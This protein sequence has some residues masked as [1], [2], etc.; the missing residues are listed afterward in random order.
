M[1]QHNNRW[2]SNLLHM[3]G[4][5]CKFWMFRV[6]LFCYFTLFVHSNDEKP[7]NI[8]YSM[9]TYIGTTHTHIPKHT[10]N[11]IEKFENCYQITIDFYPF[12]AKSKSSI[13]QHSPYVCLCSNNF[14]RSIQSIAS[15]V[16]YFRCK[17]HC[18]RYSVKSFLFQEK[19]VVRVCYRC[20][21]CVL[22][23]LVYGEYTHSLMWVRA[24][25][26]PMTIQKRT[27][28]FNANSNETYATH[29]HIHNLHNSARNTCAKWANEHTTQSAY[30]LQFSLY[31]HMS[32]CMCILEMIFLSRFA[33][34]KWQ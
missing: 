13:G 16:W 11:S 9:H 31:V 32:M 21:F 17:V 27:I 12:S 30:A 20:I 15:T 14:Q 26:R 22:I 2:H 4:C 19:E 24:S 1:K 3:Y 5:A 8:V 25:A 29:Q 7:A 28:F 33:F 34:S 10:L 6:C 23:V 18:I